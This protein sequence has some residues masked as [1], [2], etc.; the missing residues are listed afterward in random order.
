MA[1][2]ALL[3][4][5]EPL[6]L[7]V[8]EHFLQQIPQVQIVGKCESALEA[9]GI[10]S[11]TAVDVVFLDIQMPGLNGLD[12]IRALS[13]KPRIVIVSAYRHY[14]V[15]S[16]DLDVVDYLLKPVAFPRLLRAVQKVLQFSS[17]AEEAP[18]TTMPE[19]SSEL[20]PDHLFIKVDKKLVKVKL[21]S[22]LY[23]ESLKDYVRVITPDENYITY[24]TLS[25]FT[26][27]LPEQ[28]FIRTHRSYTIAIDKVEQVEGNFAI[29]SGNYIPLARNRKSIV[30]DRLIR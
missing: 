22:I 24:C 16:Y 2:K 1:L 11:R 7:E 12:F 4:D 10:L 29:I 28:Q 3:V 9:F 27:Q 25:D 20:Q 13:H 14:A 26:G 18:A 5:D 30:L 21:E 23:I 6:A 8:L 19:S 15:E 17:L